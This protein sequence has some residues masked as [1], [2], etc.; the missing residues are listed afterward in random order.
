[1]L[2]FLGGNP[3]VIAAVISMTCVFGA[4]DPDFVVNFGVDRRN[5]LL[6]RHLKAQVNKGKLSDVE[7]NHDTTYLALFSL[8]FLLLV[9]I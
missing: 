5:V 3:A 8:L 4:E 9:H 1:M 7:M 2:I 6:G